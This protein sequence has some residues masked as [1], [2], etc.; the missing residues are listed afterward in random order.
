M[1]SSPRWL[2]KHFTAKSVISP[3]K[4]TPVVWRVAIIYQAPSRLSADFQHL[5][6]DFIDTSPANECLRK[7]MLITFLHV[8]NQLQLLTGKVFMSKSWEG[9]VGRRWTLNSSGSN[10]R[11]R[12][13]DA[14]KQR[15]K[16]VPL[17]SADVRGS[18]EETSPKNVYPGGYYRCFDGYNLHLRVTVLWTLLFS[19]IFFFLPNICKRKFCSKKYRSPCSFRVNGL[20]WIKVVQ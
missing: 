7:N 6:Q 20:A 18:T 12:D 10:V 15:A 11:S 4:D 8:L 2:I 17:A 13:R 14:N 19:Y 5:G 3:W 16:N 9:S 1:K